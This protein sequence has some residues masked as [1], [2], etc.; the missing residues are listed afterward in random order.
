MLSLLAVFLFTLAAQTAQELPPPPP[1]I[2][3]TAVEDDALRAAIAAWNSTRSVKT[4]PLVITRE[5]LGIRPEVAPYLRLELLRRG[6]PAPLAEQLLRS[7]SERNSQR[8]SLESVA[9]EGVTRLRFVDILFR[10]L[11]PK[12]RFDPALQNIDKMR[13]VTIPGTAGDS[14]IIFSY[15]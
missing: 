5:S 12:I 10:G 6:I 8:W 9:L 1:A 2:H 13:S 7:L 14:A 3:L 4:S 15:V 11:D